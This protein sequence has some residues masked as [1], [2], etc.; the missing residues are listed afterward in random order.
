MVAYDPPV[1]VRIATG[2]ILKTEALLAAATR[3]LPK[4]QAE[5]LLLNQFGLERETVEIIEESIPEVRNLA[6]NPKV[7][8][9]D[10]PF[11][12]GEV[13]DLMAETRA[14]LRTL[15]MIASVN[16]SLDQPALHR[17]AS[18][19][20][21]LIES[22]PRDLLRDLERRLRAV[23]DLK[24][25]LRDAGL[26][27]KFIDRGQKL[28]VQLQTAI[29]AQDVGAEDLSFPQ[30]QLYARRFDLYSRLKRAVRLAQLAF[31]E[32]PKQAADFHLDELEPRLVQPLPLQ[33][34][35]P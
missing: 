28:Y 34:L 1:P 9:H 16:L 20:P 33:K 4:I 26:T 35:L 24:S 7:R 11:Q 2:A 15:R 10:T 17:L 6:K 29:G 31:L 27:D 3:L 8:K 13:L 22:Y 18:P 23:G 5:Y 19:E 12:M 32:S 21:E 30:R 25:R 14:W